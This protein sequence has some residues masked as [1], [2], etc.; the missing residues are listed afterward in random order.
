MLRRTDSATEQAILLALC[1]R[2]YEHIKAEREGDNMANSF[3]GYGPQYEASQVETDLHN[4]LLECGLI[5]PS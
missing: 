1:K 3:Q 5:P 4:V 2:A